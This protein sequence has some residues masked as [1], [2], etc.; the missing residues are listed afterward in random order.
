M[1]IYGHV[2]ESDSLFGEDCEPE[3]NVHK[4]ELLDLTK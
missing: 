2:H 3:K 4:Y 1:S